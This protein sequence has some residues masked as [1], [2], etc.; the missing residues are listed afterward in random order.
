MVLEHV[1]C[2]LDGFG[3]A[4]ELFELSFIYELKADVFL[5]PLH[6]NI[7]LVTST[8]Q[9]VATFGYSIFK[10]AIK[11]KSLKKQNKTKNEVI[12]VGPNPV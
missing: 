11:T 2:Q 10:E 3:Q 9:D 5:S 4:I 1:T 8:T 6:S 7:K 12:R